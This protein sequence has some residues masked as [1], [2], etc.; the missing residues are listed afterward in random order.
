MQPDFLSNEAR[1]RLIQA[2]VIASISRDTD[3]E[4]KADRLAS[5]VKF[6]SRH[7]G[8]QPVEFVKRCVGE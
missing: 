4:R 5:A 8:F 3:P 7:E 1:W 6:F 2:M